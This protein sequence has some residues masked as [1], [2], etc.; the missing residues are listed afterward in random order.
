MTSR[1]V[2]DLTAEVRRAI[3]AHAERDRPRECC[4]LL[5]GRGRRVRVALPMR[6]IARLST[7]RFRLDAAEHVAV[8]R[9]LREVAPALE[10]IGAY[11]SHP[12]GRAW[13]SPTDVKNAHYP[14]WTHIIIGLGTRRP[15]V[16]AFRI[17]NG[18]V[19]RLRLRY[20][21]GFRRSRRVPSRGA[22]PRASSA[23]R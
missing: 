16:R 14:E 3:V 15:V 7:R 19:E 1:G 23:S 17:R 21:P 13:P 10:I 4:G 22:S 5:A 20:H 12:V 6:N 8:R 18:R 11:H 2:L 9:V